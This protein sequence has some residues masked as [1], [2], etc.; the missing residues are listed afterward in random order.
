MAGVEVREEAR[1]SVRRKVRWRVKDGGM[2][3]VKEDE[4]G[5]GGKIKDGGNT[6]RT[7]GRKVGMKVEVKHQEREGKGRNGKV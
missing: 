4:K 6:G 5:G 3:E 7:T 1:G 2:R